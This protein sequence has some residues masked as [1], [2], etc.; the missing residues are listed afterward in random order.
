MEE[1]CIIYFS[2]STKFFEE[3]S[4]PILL[5]Q[6]RLDNAKVNITGI[7]LYV[8]GS[9]MQV[10]EG[11][12]QAIET[13]FDRIQ[14]DRRHTDVTR[15]MNRPIA[16]RLFP[17]WTMGYETVTRW[18]MEDIKATVVLDKDRSAS[19]TI[20]PDEPLILRLIKVFYDSNRNNY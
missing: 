11:E 4:L 14:T 20:Q 12:S 17:D 15:V 3:S 10:L 2:Q 16:Q 19:V 5:E 1:R 18:Q 6:W 13:L 9:I 8:Q 7:L